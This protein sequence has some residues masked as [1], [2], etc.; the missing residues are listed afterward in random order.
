MM[1]LAEPSPEALLASVEAAIDR[2]PHLDPA[3]QHE[4]VRSPFA[5]VF[6]EEGGGGLPGYGMS[7]L[8]PSRSLSL[9]LTLSVPTHNNR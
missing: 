6:C 3:A 8:F 2:V 5:F 9:S 4:R 7:C 1:L